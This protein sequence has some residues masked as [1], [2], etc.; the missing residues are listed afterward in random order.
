MYM[1]QILKIKLK[2][3]KINT[4]NAISYIKQSQK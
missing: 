1:E 3:P 4:I 2:M